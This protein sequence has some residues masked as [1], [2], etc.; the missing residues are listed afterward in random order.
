M[1]GFL[2]VFRK[3][4]SNF[5]VSPIA[6]TV[7]AIFS[8]V[9][10]FFFWANVSFMSLISLQAASNPMIAQRI[11]LTDIVIRPLTQNMAIILLFVMPLLTMRLF[12]EEKKSGTMELL[13][14]Y[15]IDDKA[16]VFGKFLASVAL[17]LIMLVGAFSFPILLASVAQPDFGVILS[18]YLGLF[19]MGAAF[20]AL[21]TFISSLTENQIVAAA[22]TFG[23]AIL[24]W[25]LS[26]TSSLVGQSTG[27]VLRQLSIL[28]HL[29]SFNKGILS[30][31]D[32]SFFILFIA[33]FVFLCLRSLETHR[34]RG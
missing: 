7:I 10:G 30:A 17:L 32:L 9:S 29:E 26:W 6:Y 15:P 33:F 1:H 18:S 27:T 8:L 20:M 12:S 11:N 24:F 2:A 21:G 19:L 3:E 13:L 25:V 31:P 34:W 16:F 14:T 4:I 22:I 28:E 5:F 23:A